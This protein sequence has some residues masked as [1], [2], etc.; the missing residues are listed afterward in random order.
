MTSAGDAHEDSSHYPSWVVEKKSVSPLVNHS[1]YGWVGEDE[2]RPVTEAQPF[3][4]LWGEGGYPHYEAFQNSAAPH[5]L[6]FASSSFGSTPFFPQ[7]RTP[8]IYESTEPADHQRK[9]HVALETRSHSFHSGTQALNVTARASNTPMISPTM[10]SSESPV[11]SLEASQSPK[12]NTPIL[13][14]Q[15]P[16]RPRKRPQSSHQSIR[17]VK[18]PQSAEVCEEKKI[19]CLSEGC[20]CRF[21]FEKDLKRHVQTKHDD[22][23]RWVCPKCGISSYDLG[24][25]KRHCKDCGV[26]EHVLVE[27][28]IKKRT[29]RGCSYCQHFSPDLEDFFAHMLSHQGHPHLSEASRY[30]NLISSLLENPRYRHI[31]KPPERDIEARLSHRLQRYSCLWDGLNPLRQELEYA[32][33]NNEEATTQLL[34]ILMTS[35]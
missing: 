5:N 10:P 30:A 28:C 23:L 15:Q 2:S 4:G 17:T 20:E 31:L 32:S 18:C 14:R 6:P 35:F 26:G 12:L 3:A 21:Y 11:S 19:I 33:A 29:G 9:P 16:R 13:K 24:Q 1:Q 22:T 8:E 7:N 25:A 34:Q 27:E